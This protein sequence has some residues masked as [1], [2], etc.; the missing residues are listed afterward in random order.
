[1]VAAIR[2]LENQN[3]K[4]PLPGEISNLLG[5]SESSIRLQL[6][7]LSNLGIVV[8]VDSAFETH[9]EIKNYL[10]IEK[11]SDEAGPAIA[12]DLAAF[13]LKKEEEA[14]RMANLFE[15]GDHEKKRKDRM[16]N[17]DKELKEFKGRKVIN[18]FGED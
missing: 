3:E 17:M 10:D 15:S 18:P 7:K 14:R 6:N 4:L 2:V 8:L 5:I 13:D 9:V 16:D 12:E 11:L 1:M